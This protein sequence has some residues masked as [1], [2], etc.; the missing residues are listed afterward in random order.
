MKS[1]KIRRLQAPVANRP[2]LVQFGCAVSNTS[3]R[4][5]IMDGA[6]WKTNA[7]PVAHKAGPTP[8]AVEK[9]IPLIL[10][11]CA[12]GMAD[13][14]AMPL[15]RVRKIVPVNWNPNERGLKASVIIND[16]L[17]PID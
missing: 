16:L 8:N 1:R 15:D 13:R 6:S 7:I 2:E 4:G 3:N 10:R 14:T 17:N 11:I 5:W 9:V 12:K